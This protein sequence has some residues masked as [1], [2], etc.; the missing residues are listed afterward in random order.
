MSETINSVEQLEQSDSNK[1][2]NNPHEQ[3]TENPE[4]A[5][6]LFA[7]SIISED[8]RA[9]LKNGFAGFGTI[10]KLSLKVIKNDFQ[11]AFFIPALCNFGLGFTFF[12]VVIGSFIFTLLSFT[13]YGLTTNTQDSIGGLILL[14]V[15]LFFATVLFIIISINF[16]IRWMLLFNN[17]SLSFFQNK[18]SVRHI[19]WRFIGTLVM[20]SLIVQAISG[21]MTMLGNFIPVI[22]NLASLVITIVVGI[23][24]K[25][26]VH[27][28]VYENTG[29]LSS[30][31][32]SYLLTKTHLGKLFLRDWLL[33]GLIFYVIPFIIVG[34]IVVSTLFSTIS[35]LNLSEVLL[36]IYTLVSTFSGLAVFLLIFALYLSLVYVLD[37]IFSYISYYNLRHNLKD[38]KEADFQK[39]YWKLD[40]ALIVLIIIGLVIASSVAGVGSREDAFLEDIQKQLDDTSF[41]SVTK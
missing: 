13:G 23:I 16:T 17:K 37:V 14:T 21:V 26:A 6:D 25:F 12:V 3:R 22:F 41:S 20:A 19:F 5:Q 9:N 15:F 28:S 35:S 8:D 2:Q 31:K 4:V 27:F 38:I 36:A 10:L 32:K 11:R 1:M 39:T 34:V 30:L 40:N 29:V 7:D 33:F 24:I 18:I